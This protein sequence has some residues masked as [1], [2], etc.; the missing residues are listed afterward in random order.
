MGLAAVSTADATPTLHI[1]LN[2]IAQD[3]AITPGST[4]SFVDANGTGVEYVAGKTNKCAPAADEPAAA[5][6]AEESPEEEAQA[7][8]LVSEYQQYE[9]ATVEEEGE[10]EEAA[11]DEGDE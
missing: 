6:A 11:D 2:G 8:D 5:P 9:D 7:N 1:A 4:G 3:V 10:F